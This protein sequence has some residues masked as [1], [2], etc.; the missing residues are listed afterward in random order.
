MDEDKLALPIPCFILAAIKY[1][2]RDTKVSVS[3]YCRDIGVIGLHCSKYIDRG[4]IFS[5]LHEGEALHF[6]KGEGHSNMFKWN[7]TQKN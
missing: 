4:T 3:S 6:T 2:I 5:V 7:K 1:V